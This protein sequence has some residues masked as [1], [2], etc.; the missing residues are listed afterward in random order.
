M[1]SLGLVQEETAIETSPE[2][3]EIDALVAQRTAARAAKDW[4]ESDRIRDLLKERGII[5]EDTKEGAK[6]HRV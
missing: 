2:D 1:L 5:I 3:A 4:A 6:W